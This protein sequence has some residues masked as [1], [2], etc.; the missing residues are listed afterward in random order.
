MIDYE[1]YCRIRQ[2]HD[3]SR[4]NA[5]QIGRHLYI[6]P[7]TVRKWLAMDKYAPRKSSERPSILDPWKEKIREMLKKHDYTARQVFRILQEDGYSGGIS[8]LRDYVSMVRPPGK[9]PFL[10]LHF[11]PG[12][13]AQVDFAH[14]GHLDINGVRKRLYALVITLCHSR[15]MFVRFILRQNMEHFLQGQRDAFEFFKGVPRKIIVDNCKVAVSRFSCH[16]DAVFNENYLDFARH[17]G[18]QI[19]PCNPGQAH[20]KGIVERGI[21]YLRQSFLRGLEITGLEAVNNGVRHWLDTVA[22]VRIHRTTRKKPVDMFSGEQPRL[23]PLPPI[24]YDCCAVRNVR[25]NSQFRIS[26]ETNRYSVPSE[27]AYKTVCQKTYVDRLE[28][29]YQNRLIA[30]HRRSYAEHQDFENPDHVSSLLLERRR[31]RDRKLLAGFLTI[32]KEA[33]A[34]Y[35]GL[36]NKRCRTDTHVRKIMALVDRYGGDAVARAVKD[37]LELQAFSS[38]YI[39]NI[40]EQRQ[41]RLPEPGPLHITRKTDCLDI[42]LEQPDLGIYDPSQ[43]NNIEDNENEQDSTNT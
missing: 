1:T 31:A 41:R 19:I 23:R 34:Y 30:R 38:D 27:Y 18:F 13:A 24:P 22:N 6:S 12:E 3:H 32:S 11:D 15:M 35:H 29:H 10:T 14:T 26:F 7:I 33:E 28:F 20:E 21:S 5:C 40:I 43:Y 17:Y 9:T 36:K 37:A 4:L 8:V 42:E 25:V 16:G 2:L 39:A